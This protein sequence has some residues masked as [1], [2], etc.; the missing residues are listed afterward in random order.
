MFNR[1]RW[2]ITLPY[3]ALILVTMLGLGIYLSNLV[4]N[5]RLETL[6]NDLLGQASLAANT[7]ETLSPSIETD[8]SIFETLP[9][10]WQARTNARFTIIAKDGTVLGESNIDRTEMKNHANRPEVIAALADGVGMSIRLSETLGE[11]YLY[12]AVPVWLDGEPQAIVRAAL[13]VAT[14]RESADVVERGIFAA[15]L[16]VGFSSFFIAAWIASRT[17]APL[18]QLTLATRQIAGG[19]KL[20]PITPTTR[21]EVG[22]LTHAFNLMA[23]NL[24]MQLSALES[25][26]QKLAAILEQMSNGVIITDENGIVL[27][28]NK[29]AA[30]MCRVEGSEPVSRTLAEVVRHHELIEAWDECQHTNEPQDLLLEI[31]PQRIYWQ[32][33]V[34]PLGGYLSGDT[35]LLL[36]D[37]SHVRHLETVRRDF[38]SNISHELRTP[39]ASLKALAETLLDG[40][41]DEPPVARRFLSRMETEVDA[42][43]LMVQELLELSRIESGRVPLQFVETDPV[44]LVTSVAER[45]DMQAE[46]KNVEVVLELPSDLPMI[47]ADTPRLEQALMNLHHNA[48]KFTDARG[49]I[50]LGASHR[51]KNI[52]F[53]VQDTGIGISADELP[54][55]FERFYKSDKARSTRGTGLGLAI[56]RHL[57]EAHGGK[58]WAESEFGRGSTFFF[59]IPSQ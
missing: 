1:I 47:L 51:G 12:V 33:T 43:I 13:P 48:I 11:E 57:V 42:L 7:L 54:R 49:K 34:S 40:A 41:L 9:K 28:M 17:T 36:Q 16:F 26:Q 2:R 18:Q 5:N 50:T 8:K 15:A 44:S 24:Q 27:L 52:V 38:I 29:V 22:E 14:I 31:A 37:M 58:I 3:T 46:R 4:R 20:V 45:L 56:T 35:L 30:E 23:Q 55:I 21:D 53:Y 25:E 32:T 6:E 19:G 10:Q 59:S 39:L